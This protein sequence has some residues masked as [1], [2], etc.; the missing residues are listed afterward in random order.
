[1]DAVKWVSLI[2]LLA[3][4]VAGI[5]QG[6]RVLARR[7]AELAPGMPVGGRVAGLLGL[8]YVLG[9]LAAGALAVWWL[10]AGA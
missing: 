5:V 6:G 9:G 1:M 4:G 2:I 8:V 10:L 7:T 3:V